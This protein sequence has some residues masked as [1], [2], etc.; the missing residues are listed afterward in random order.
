VHPDTTDAAPDPTAPDA[1]Q[2]WERRY[3]DAGQVWS[4][5]ANQTLADIA[6]HLPVGRALDLGCGEG[7]DA[8]WLARAGWRVT[9]I[10]ISPTAIARAASAASDLS[11]GRIEWVAADLDQWTRDR[12]HGP[13]DLVTASFLH[14][15]VEIPRTAILRRAAGFVAADGYLLIVSH[16]AFPPWSN[17]QHDDHRFLGPAEE[18]AELALPDSQWDVRL[19]ETRPRDAT[20]PDGQRATLD[21]AVVLLHRR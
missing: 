12:S 6:S 7:G 9:A 21:D 10:D 11:D 17:H 20:G 14:S 13:Y 1:A 8:I 4:G 19:A 16:A 5:R 15:L 18:I 2:Y 3:A